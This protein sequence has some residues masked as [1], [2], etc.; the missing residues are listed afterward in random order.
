[1]ITLIHPQ[2]SPVNDGQTIEEGLKKCGGKFVGAADWTSNVCVD[3]NL[4][5]GQNPASSKACA[6]AVAKALA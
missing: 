1:M 2:S 3:G 5:T 4:I 6:D